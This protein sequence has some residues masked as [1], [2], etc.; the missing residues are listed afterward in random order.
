MKVQFDDFSRAVVIALAV[1]CSTAVSQT[2]NV[3]SQGVQAANSK[4]KDLFE[5]S[6]AVCHGLDGGGGQHAPNIGRASTAK[7]KS[8]SALA[9]ILRDGIISKGMPSFNY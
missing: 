9:H 7:S 1:L 3:K 4:G 6:C 2:S 8:D 5:S